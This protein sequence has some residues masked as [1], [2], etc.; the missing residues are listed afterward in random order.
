MGKN[1]SLLRDMEENLDKLRDNPCPHMGWHHDIND[2][3]LPFY[4]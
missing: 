3:F 4:P 2:S 1:E